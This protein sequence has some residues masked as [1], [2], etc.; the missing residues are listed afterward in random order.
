[1]RIF[2]YSE[3]SPNIPEQTKQAPLAFKAATP[4]EMLASKDKLPLVEDFELVIIDGRQNPP[5]K[6]LGSDIVV[7]FVNHATNQRITQWQMY[8]VDTDPMDMQRV[9]N[10]TKGKIINEIEMGYHVLITTDDEF[11]YVAYSE[12]DDEPTAY[13]RYCKIPKNR[14]ESEW[15]AFVD[16]Y[17]EHPEKRHPH[18][19]PEERMAQSA[20]NPDGSLK[21]RGNWLTRLFG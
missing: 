9:P 11:V 16:W 8:Y 14:Y 6:P 3:T 15:K 2:T 19:T 20:R 1:M 7:Q 21:K 17:H 12:D 18:P 5:E 4:E 10:P 13:T